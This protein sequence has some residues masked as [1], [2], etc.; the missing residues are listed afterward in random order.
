MK[1]HECVSH[2]WKLSDAKRPIPTKQPLLLV[3]EPLEEPA[4]ARDGSESWSQWKLVAG[5]DQLECFAE[6]FATTSD[7]FLFRSATSETTH[8]ASLEQLFL[9]KFPR[10]I[11]Q[12]QQDINNLQRG[13]ALTCILKSPPSAD[14]PLFAVVLQLH[15]APSDGEYNASPALEYFLASKYLDDH[16]PEFSFSPA[17]LYEDVRSACLKWKV[18]DSRPEGLADATQSFNHQLRALSWMGARESGHIGAY[19]NIEAIKAEATHSWVPLTSKVHYSPWLRKLS[20]DFESI[21]GDFTEPRGGILADEMGMGKTVEVI[22]LILARPFPTPEQL[23]RQYLDPELTPGTAPGAPSVTNITKSTNLKCYCTPSARKAAPLRN[24]LV[25][26]CRYCSTS[27]HLACVGYDFKLPD[28]LYACPDCGSQ[29]RDEKELSEKERDDPVLRRMPVE[30]GATLIVCPDTILPQWESEMRRHVVPGQIRY[31]VFRGKSHANELY[32]AE[33]FRAYDVVITTYDVLAEALLRNKSNQAQKQ[34]RRRNEDSLKY[35]AMPSPLVGAIWYRVCF[36]ESQMLGSGINRAAQLSL[37]LRVRHRWAVSGTPISRSCADLYGL[38]LFLD[39]SPYSD[40]AYWRQIIEAPMERGHRHAEEIL[41]SLLTRIMWRTEKKDADE[42][43]NTM[44]G[45]TEHVHEVQFSEVERYMYQ[46]RWKYVEE[47]LLLTKQKRLNGRLTVEASSKMVADLI[48]LRMACCHHQLGRKTGLKD[49]TEGVMSAPAVFKQLIHQARLQAENRQANRV[50][51]WHGLAALCMAEEKWSEAADFYRSVLD[52]G[53][54]EIHT[55]TN[56]LY[57]ARHNLIEALEHIMNTSEDAATIENMEVEKAQLQALNDEHCSKYMAAARE[58]YTARTFQ[59][60]Q[61]M[62]SL[63]VDPAVEEAAKQNERLR[64]EAEESKRQEEIKRLEDEAIKRR[65][66]EEEARRQALVEVERQTDSSPPATEDAPNAM[67]IEDGSQLAVNADP[68]TQDLEVAQPSEDSV[69]QSANQQS[70]AVKVEQPDQPSLTENVEQTSVI[71]T[72]EPHQ[73]EELKPLDAAI[74]MDLSEPHSLEEE[75]HQLTIPEIEAMIQTIENEADL[76]LEPIEGASGFDAF[77]HGLVPPRFRMELRFWVSRKDSWWKVMLENIAYFERTEAELLEKLAVDLPQGALPG[78]ALLNI[79]SLTLWLDKSMEKVQQ[80]VDDLANAVVKVCGERNADGSFPIVNEPPVHRLIERAT[81]PHCLSRRTA[82]DAKKKRYANI[83]QTNQKL[84]MWCPLKEKAQAVIKLFSSAPHNLFVSVLSVILRY[85]ERTRNRDAFSLWHAVPRHL[86][87]P[88]PASSDESEEFEEDSHHDALELG[89]LDDGEDSE[90]ES[91]QIAPSPLDAPISAATASSMQIDQPSTPKQPG[92]K[93]REAKRRNTQNVEELDAEI[94]PPR[95]SKL[96]KLHESLSED[97]DGSDEDVLPPFPQESDYTLMR[98]LK[99]TQRVR[100]DAVEAARAMFRAID[101]LKR[102]A[103]AAD[104]VCDSHREYT[105]CGE[106]LTMVATRMRLRNELEPELD[107]VQFEQALFTRAEIPHLR[108]DYDQHLRV[109]QFEFQE[110]TSQLRYLTTQ[111]E[112]VLPTNCPICWEELP[113]EVM[114]L[115]CGH[116]GC[117]NCMKKAFETAARCPLCRTRVV[118]ADT[119]I[120]AREGGLAE[121]IVVPDAAAKATKYGSKI[122]AIV[123]LVRKEMER[124]PGEKFLIFSHWGQVITLL[125][126][127]L[128]EAGISSISSFGDKFAATLD[129]FRSDSTISVLCI[130]LHRGS[131]GA[132]LMCASHIIFA[133]PSLLT[134]SEAQAIGRIHRLGQTRKMKVHRFFVANSIEQSIFELSQLRR[135]QYKQ[136]AS[137]GFVA[138]DREMNILNL[139]TLEHLLRGGPL[140]DV[141]Q[142]EVAEQ[143]GE[144]NARP[145]RPETI[146]MED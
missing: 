100:D 5:K 33:Q 118:K 78:R 134:A 27:Q 6:K 90:G 138:Q 48:T 34:F 66:A 126:A 103:S 42:V 25:V 20:F 135:A 144:E 113:A 38:M 93:V 2:G 86:L 47:K 146:T 62:D 52:P 77:P 133:E 32:R 21:Q 51:Y 108:A 139:D 124:C 114:L 13:F 1:V 96:V 22:S 3:I 81:C 94:S 39:I 92:P 67:V 119:K 9:S 98:R 79:H 145:T 115:T 50:Y 23:E 12:Y 36:D 56:P 109:A 72:A 91:P 99:R 11:V 73:P 26:T 30:V 132:N 137:V 87:D 69:Q 35:V 125:S 89:D 143:I 117:P 8:T 57:H 17:P 106:E 40:R 123:E 49:L 71:A 18:C 131:K 95:P 116:S 142:K 31:T 97:E 80:S 19:E 140:E 68:P 10:P 70:V 65:E 83:E 46:R 14:D 53:E 110:Q 129:R 37:E 141:V 45:L 16:D 28:P 59:Y 7:F 127:A 74:K 4:L 122:D 84:C 54:F 63:L 120:V 82:Q 136:K 111:A 85:I 101:I 104:D 112:T 61:V 128:Q 76:P 60:A 102:L 75:P 88:E 130:P 55:G 107:D 15:V 41:K 43:M 44:P 58:L 29:A 24:S 64:L 121:P 105:N